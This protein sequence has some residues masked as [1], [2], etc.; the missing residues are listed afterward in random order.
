MATPTWYL[1][2]KMEFS[3]AHALRHYQGKCENLHGH[4]Y[5]VTVEVKGHEL[6]PG[7]ELLMDFGDLKRLTKE[8]VA[9]LDHAHINEVPPFDTVNPSSENMA[10][11]VWQRM[12]H[13]LPKNVQLHGVT[14]AERDIQHAT[15]REE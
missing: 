6:M 9:P 1:T 5:A 7:T 8:A 3:A 12:A 15:Y 11:F 14:I 2:V 4:N 13:H 10:R